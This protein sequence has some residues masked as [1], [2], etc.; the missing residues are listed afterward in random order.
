MRRDTGQ[1]PKGRHIRRQERRRGTQGRVRHIA[2]IIAPVLLYAGLACAGTLER[3][4]NTFQLAF[5]EGSGQIEWISPSTFRF[6]RSWSGKVEQREPLSG[7][8][9]EVKASGAEG[10]YRFETKYLV[11]EIDDAGSR[12]TVND[13]ERR[14]L[15]STV[16]KGA[17]ESA[18]APGERFYGLGPRRPAKLD[19]RGSAI[20]T[21]RPFLISSEG[22]GEYF[23]APGRYKYDLG[24]AQ[25]GRRRTTAP[26][27]RV[28]FYFYYGPRPKDILDEHLTVAGE[29]RGTYEFTL[30]DRGGAAQAGSWAALRDAI[31]EQEQASFSAVMAAPFDL[32]PFQAAGG[33]VLDSAT[34]IAGVLPRV[35]T[36]RGDRSLLMKERERWVPYLA[37]YGYEARVRGVPFLRAM[38]L[39]F[40][41]DE[42]A[43]GRTAQ[44][45]IGDELMVAPR[46]SEE[47][48]V[49]VYLPQGIWTDLRTNA[50]YRGRQE[51][52]VDAADSMPM[53]SRNGQI[54][55][56]AE[57]GVVQL[58][59]FPKLA[60][61]FF[62]YESG[63]P[64]VTQVHAAPAVDVYR[65]EIESQVTRDY[66][67]VIRHIGKCTKVVGDG[68]EFTEVHDAKALADR[69]WYYDA[70]IQAIRVRVHARAGADHIVN[71]SF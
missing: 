21:E 71:I 59:Y 40:P 16:A 26:G 3:A 24:A 54:L 11:V 68:V 29:D 27:E 37:S 23:P 36:A 45:M 58:H 28:E 69:T 34:Q 31:L 32:G 14:L 55:P 70:A 46:L 62:I 43:A 19:L 33:A 49:S 22:Y 57:G 4:G 52:V 25:A 10:K 48:K 5:T 47:S 60:A 39:E 35:L 63:I 7:E 51:I 66:E 61:E 2:A 15:A 6:T 20:E 9:V 12:L 1:P 44:F 42:R 65:T 50:V 8:M 53:F 67:W 41:E 13:P 18:I 64:E 56:I 17:V 38:A 30:R